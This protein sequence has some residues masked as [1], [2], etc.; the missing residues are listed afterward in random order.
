MEI[1]LAK[2]LNFDRG[3]GEINLFKM[4]HIF[5]DE[6]LFTNIL[7]EFEKEGGVMSHAKVYMACKKSA[8]KYFENFISNS[9]IG[10]LMRK[11]KWGRVELVRQIQPLWSD[12]GFGVVA[13]ISSQEDCITVRIN[14]NINARTH[15]RSSLPVCYFTQGILA[16]IASVIYNGDY[17]CQEVKCIAVGDACCEFVIKPAELLKKAKH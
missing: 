7:N 8:K 3:K 4:R 6:N 13:N 1:G 14:N 2:E 16:G 11:F 9:E 5:I 12:Y 10:N 15:E 17:D